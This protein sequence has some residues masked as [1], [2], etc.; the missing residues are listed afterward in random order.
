[1]LANYPVYTM[2]RAADVGRARQF[3]TETLDLSVAYDMGSVFGVAAGNG[4]IIS[5]YQRDGSRAPEN[6]AAVWQVDD[7]DSVARDLIGRG[8]IPERYEMPDV[9]FDDLGIATLG[10]ARA[11]WF[12]DSEDNILMVTQM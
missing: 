4:T 10:G 11:L 8:V 7:I 12:T 2:L 1:M 9:E 5:V 3:Y 6:N